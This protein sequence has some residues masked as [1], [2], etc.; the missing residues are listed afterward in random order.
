MLSPGLPSATGINGQLYISPTTP[1]TLVPSGAVGGQD[2]LAVQYRVR[3]ETAPPPTFASNL[4]FPLHWAKSGFSRNGS[5]SPIFVT[6]EDGRY[7][8]EFSG[9][10][11][12][13]TPTGLVVTDTE[14][15][16]RVT[17]VLDTTPPV[18]TP[19]ANLEIPATEPRGARVKN[20]RA[21][22]S[23]FS[24]AVPRDALDPSPTL[25]EPQMAGSTITPTTLFPIGAT[26]VT[27]RAKDAIGNLGTASAT[28]TVVRGRPAF[29]ISVLGYDK[30]EK[31]R[32][33][34]SLKLSNTGSGNGKNLRLA[35]IEAKS[36]AGSGKM[37]ILELSYLGSPATL[38]LK[39][40]NVDSGS[41]THLI[42]VYYSGSHDSNPVSFAVTGSVEDVTGATIAFHALGQRK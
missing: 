28:V 35:S 36:I 13:S 38:P 8:L 27:F 4:P 41:D 39:I 11:A 21:L 1:I 3:K 18:I 25:L 19:P 10:R 34:A 23:F 42:R 22:N 30:D 32:Q 24:S 12:T 16:H 26:P 40:G 6:G 7:T 31:G 29:S 20:S 37:T 14:I 5:T 33:F 9:Q 17:V 2:S 15:R